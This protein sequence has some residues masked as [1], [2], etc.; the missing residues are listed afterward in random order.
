[1]ITDTET[2]RQKIEYIHNNPVKRGMVVKPEDWVYSSATNYL[3]GD[4]FMEVD[5][6]AF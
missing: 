5:L 3:W 1:M 2:L 6:V 4:G